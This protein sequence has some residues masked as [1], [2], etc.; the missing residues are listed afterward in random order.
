MGVPMDSD[1]SGQAPMDAEDLGI[2]MDKMDKEQQGKSAVIDQSKVQADIAAAKALASQGKLQQAIDALLLVEKA[3]RTAEDYP[4]TSVAC[5]TILELLHSAGQWKQLMET[6]QLLSKRRSQLK[7]AIKAMVKQAMSY[8]DSDASKMDQATRTEMIETLVTL[9]EGK[10]FVEIERARLTRL[11][12]RMKE[13]EGKIAE[14]AE[15]LQ[16]IAVETYGSMSKTEKISFILEQVR[17]CLDRGDYVRAQIMARKISPR[18]FASENRIAAKAK[19]EAA[20]AKDKIDE[21]MADAATDDLK[22]SSS[23]SKK[24]G[25]QKPEIGIE[26][27]AVE[28]P[29]EGTASLEQLKLQYHSLMIRYYAHTSDYLEIARAYRSVLDTPIIEADVARAQDT[30]AKAAWYCVLSPVSSD[31]ATLLE[32]TKQDKRMEDLP[33]LAKLL[34]GFSGNE[35]LWWRQIKQDMG[36]EM[37]DA[38][39]IFG[40][41]GTGTASTNTVKEG[42]GG[43]GGGAVKRK[44]DLRLRVTQ[45]NILV[46][47]K[48]YSHISAERLAQMLELTPSEAEKCLSDMVVGGAVAAKIDRPAGVVT[49]GA[50]KGPAAALNSWSGNVSKLLELVEKSCQAIQKE[51]QVHKVELGVGS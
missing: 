11:L 17:L 41:T 3:G 22:K 1:K 30:L 31:Q 19:R 14:A 33:G 27:T 37:A 49:F 10:I 26:G 20:D 9:T 7:Q 35:I 23:S 43:E 47:S 28:P 15:L 2:E 38:H 48:Y 13:A 39:D 51:V 25:E 4:S 8:I 36:Q 42:G 29:P 21:D 18:A 40:G 24:G 16:E 32:L 44:E 34:K 45:H 5:T 6:I 12:A 50:K 46:I